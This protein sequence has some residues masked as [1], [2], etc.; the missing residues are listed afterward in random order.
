MT[1]LLSELLTELLSDR[2]DPRDAY[3]S[4]KIP[5]IKP[6][7]IVFTPV[8]LKFHSISCLTFPN[9]PV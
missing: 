1:E 8:Y 4:K 6:I 2:V 9:V 7:Y 5:Y 3:A